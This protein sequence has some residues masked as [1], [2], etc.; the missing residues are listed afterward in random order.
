MPRQARIDIA[1]YPYHVILRGNN[2]SAIFHNDRDRRFFI[3]CLQESKEKTKTKIYGYCL[4]TNHVH[5]LVEPREDKGLG[6]MMQSLG[7]KYVQYIN[8]AYKRTGT[9][10]EGRFKS[11]L[12]SKD[13]YLLAC[14][15]YIELNPIRAKMVKEIGDYFGQVLDLKVK[16]N[17]IHFL[18]KIPYILD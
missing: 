12:V 7:R 14:S 16:E 18:I 9:L 4:M 15:R 8:Q 6:N 3:N 11:S 17:Q 5:L 10:W 13:D 1:G 2:R